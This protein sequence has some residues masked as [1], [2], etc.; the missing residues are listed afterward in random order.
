[1]PGTWPALPATPPAPIAQG[2][3]VPADPWVINAAYHEAAV[4]PLTAAQLHAVSAVRAGGAES[5]GVSSFW[6][7]RLRPPWAAPPGMRPLT[8]ADAKGGEYATDNPEV[9][10]AKG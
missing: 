10:L 7:G 6:A 8:M 9:G 2:A 1:M 3:L 4:A 5:G